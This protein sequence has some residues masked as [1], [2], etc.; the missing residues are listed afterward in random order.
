MENDQNNRIILVNGG[1]GSGKNV[2]FQINYTDLYLLFNS[3]KYTLFSNFIKVN[4]IFQ[5]LS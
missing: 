4:L 2:L 1:P 3:K 5:R